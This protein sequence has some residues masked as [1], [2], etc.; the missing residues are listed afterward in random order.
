MQDCKTWL[1]AKYA[2]RPWHPCKIIA[3]EAREQGF[4]KRE[5]KDARK[6]LGIIMLSKY[7]ENY[8]ALNYFWCLPWA[9]PWP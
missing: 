4:T 9:Q 3:D 5:L 8:K 7:D 2:D 1:R 6:A